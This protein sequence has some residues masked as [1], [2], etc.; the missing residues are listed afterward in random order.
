LEHDF[1]IF[2]KTGHLPRR[3]SY[4]CCWA[5]CRDQVEGLL[6]LHASC[7]YHCTL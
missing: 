5:D 6:Q 4:C 2:L 7:T 3:T 1:K